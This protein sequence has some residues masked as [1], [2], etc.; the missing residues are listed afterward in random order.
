MVALGLTNAQI[1]DRLDVT[2]HA[3][4]FHLSH[5]YRKLGVANRTEAAVRFHEP[6]P[7]GDE[8]D[9]KGVVDWNATDAPVPAC[10][11]HELFEEV[12]A[13]NPEAVA[14]VDGHGTSLTYGELERRANKLAHH[15]RAFGA[16]PEVLVGI[17]VTRSASM[18][19]GL[20]GILKAGSAYVPI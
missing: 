13:R 6:T 11:V 4:K 3:V 5:V 17:A 7:H 15:L 10:C 1:A 19:V 8:S 2:L 9:P 18:L 14:V 16:G 12:A 20:L